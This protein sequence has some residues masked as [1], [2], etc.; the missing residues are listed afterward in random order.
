MGEW[1]SVCV[2]MGGICKQVLYM[3]HREIAVQI[4]HM[5]REELLPMTMFI[6]SIEKFKDLAS[7]CGVAQLEVNTASDWNENKDSE[8]VALMRKKILPKCPVC[9][10]KTLPRD[11]EMCASCAKNKKVRLRCISYL[12]A[13]LFISSS[14]QYWLWP[15][16]SLEIISISWLAVI[17]ACA[18][19]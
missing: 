11:K 18:W 17:D 13:F 16:S 8:T 19:L 2:S 3:M 5:S 4:W 9:Q 7:T 14:P 15:S 6:N 12:K 1:A 10:N